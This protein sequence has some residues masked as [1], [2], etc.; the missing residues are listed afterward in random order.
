MLAVEHKLQVTHPVTSQQQELI[1][2]T[3]GRQKGSNWPD[4][5]MSQ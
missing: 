1:H 4:T 5:F 2:A 3:Q